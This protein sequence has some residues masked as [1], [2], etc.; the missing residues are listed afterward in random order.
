M[1]FF[2]FVLS[3]IKVLLID[4]IGAMISAVSIGVIIPA[5]HSYFKVPLDVVYTLAGIAV[6][7]SV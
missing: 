3:S 4:G 1:T 6:G 5:F 2:V 7:F